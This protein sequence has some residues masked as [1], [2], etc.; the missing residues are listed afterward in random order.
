MKKPNIYQV[1]TGQVDVK[2]SIQAT[3]FANLDLIPGSLDLAGLAI[4]LV[5]EENREKFLKK[6]T[7]SIRTPNW[8]GR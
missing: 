7:S 3:Q 8:P 6:T 1:I 4:E 2:E 5:E